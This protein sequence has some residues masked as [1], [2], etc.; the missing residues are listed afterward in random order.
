MAQVIFPHLVDESVDS[1]NEV[2]CRVAEQEGSKEMEEVSKEVKEVSKEMEE[3]SKEVQEGSKE[4]KD[5][6]KEVEGSVVAT[7]RRSRRM[8]GVQPDSSL[9]Q[10]LGT[11]C[12]SVQTRVLSTCSLL[13]QEQLAVT[14]ARRVKERSVSGDRYTTFLLCTVSLSKNALCPETGGT[15]PTLE[16]DP[17]G[18][19]SSS[20]VPFSVLCSQFYR[21]TVF[22]CPGGDTAPL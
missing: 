2:S 17:V 4:V 14:P 9:T 12:N 1:Q 20:P 5:V 22:L 19:C 10:V 18:T 15:A 8:S 11:H 21:D 6:S 7:P 3:V 16:R 13:T